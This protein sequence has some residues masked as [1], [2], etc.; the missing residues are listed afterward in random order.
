MARI[1]LVSN[2]VAIPQEGGVHAGGLEVA[3][4]AFMREHRCIWVGWSG[5]A[6]ENPEDVKI[7]HVSEGGTDF[8]VTD[9]QRRD[10]EEYYNGFANRVLWPVLHYRIDLAE[11]SRQ[12]LS[13][14]MRV[15]ERFADLLAG[16]LEPDD[17][18]WVH[19]YHFMPLAAILRER[20]FSNRIGFFLHI[21]M[22]PPEVLAA[23]PGHKRAL[24]ALSEYDLVGF[25]TEADTA[26]FAR[27]L[28]T[29]TGTSPHFGMSHGGR[30]MRV[31]AFPVGIETRAFEAAASKAMK[32][33]IVQKLKADTS[34][35]VI[36]V[37][38][39]DYSKGLDL[40]LEAYGRFLK[41]NPGWLEK[42]TFL[43]ITPKSRSAIAEY[44]AMETQLDTVS[45]RINSTFGDALW[46]PIRYVTQAYPRETLAGFFR[47]SRVGVVTPLRDGMNLVAKEYVAAQS[48]DDPGVLVLSE[49]A[50][51]AAELTAALIVNPNDPDSVGAAVNKALTMPV[52]ER[53]HRHHAL[54][55]AL[56]RTDIAEWGDKFLKALL[57]HSID[58][59]NGEPIAA[60]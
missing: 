28:A 9:L 40:K 22:P 53:R 48:A 54:W 27:Y 44:A 55:N 30:R 35:L 57:G 4:R 43:Q 33:D 19:D 26:N 37:D 51:A 45:G 13:G 59:S 29:Q 6:V 10:Y 36:G 2:R 7:S 16:L 14:Y 1:F 32:T 25:Q 39:L 52:E 31:G 18:V 5:N 3:L 12:D 17:V 24:N 46:T 42:V 34:A 23:M 50:G 15:N 20:G 38:R 49:F 21:P 56:L 60:Q 41:A 58:E 11:F 8:V 47:A